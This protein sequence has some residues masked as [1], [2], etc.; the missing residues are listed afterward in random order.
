[1]P[2]EKKQGSLV[3]PGSPQSLHLEDPSKLLNA[4]DKK[5]LDLSLEEMARARRQA[6]AS[7]Q[8][9]RLS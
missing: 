1:M 8:N 9:I 4:A 5:R 6:E 3:V 2:E 7:S